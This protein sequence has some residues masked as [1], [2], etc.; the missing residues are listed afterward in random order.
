MLC[1]AVPA[2]K[3][4]EFEQSGRSNLHRV[5]DDATAVRRLVLSA[6][7]RAHKGHIASALSIVEMLLAC[8]L[9]H[10]AILHPSGDDTLVFSKGH[11]S[12]A[13]YSLLLLRG[14]ITEPQFNSY[15][16]NGTLLGTH[17]SPSLPSVTFGSGSL[18]QGPSVAVGHAL[19]NCMAGSEARSLCVI[20]DAEINEGSTWEAL[21]LA[22][23]LGLDRL[24]V[25]VDVNGLQALGPTS[26]V[27]R[28][29]GFPHAAE[30]IGWAVSEVDGHSVTEIR[31]ALSQERDGRP[32]LVI[33]MTTGGK[34]VSFMENRFEWHYYPMDFDQYAQAMEE[35]KGR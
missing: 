8:E 23:H 35:V 15:C 20:S 11:A 17:P 1:V 13:L 18:G 32:R 31:N 14:R 21:L 30:S 27:L 26:E 16:G 19:A 4:N 24:A 5:T 9:E 34:G 2:V 28:T 22:G 25:L 7:R 6:S 12:L 33:C 3:G 29:S 10:P